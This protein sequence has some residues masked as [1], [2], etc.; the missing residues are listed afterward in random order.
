MHSKHLRHDIIHEEADETSS[1]GS[2]SV[3][4]RLD[5]ETEEKAKREEEMKVC[6][7]LSP[8]REMEKKE[9]QL[10]LSFIDVK[11]DS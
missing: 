2:G 8:R 9:L 10:S 6:T 11:N 1:A 5:E 4:P 3:T 7:T